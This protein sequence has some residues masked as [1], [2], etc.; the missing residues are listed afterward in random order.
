[1]VIAW[2]LAA[3]RLQKQGC[4][5]KWVV[6]VQ[7]WPAS[8]SGQP[9]VHLQQRV[10]HTKQIH[11]TARAADTETSGWARQGGHRQPPQQQHARA[12]LKPRAVLEGGSGGRVVV[13]EGGHL[14]FQ[15]L[16]ASAIEGIR[17]LVGESSSI[18]SCIVEEGGGGSGIQ[19]FVYLKW[20]N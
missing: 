15:V 5:N 1:M 20:P 14:P 17:G 18:Y 13:E 12:G 6:A 4:S 9:Q 3:G 7:R 11:G 16:D 10:V 19:R 2:H 8:A